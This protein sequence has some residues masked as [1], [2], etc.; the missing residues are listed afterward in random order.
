MPGKRTIFEAVGEFLKEAKWPDQ[1][2]ST[3]DKF[4]VSLVILSIKGK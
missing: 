1:D 4:F 3:L 2:I